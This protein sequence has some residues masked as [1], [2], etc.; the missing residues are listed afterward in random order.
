MKSDASSSSVAEGRLFGIGVGPGDP[1]LLTL[2]AVRV[3]NECAVLAWPAPESGRGLAFDIAAPHLRNESQTR[4]PL[5]LPIG[6]DPF[7]AQQAYD[8]MAERLTPWLESGATVGVLCEGD[9]LFYGS[10]MYLLERLGSQFP[11]TVVPGVSSLMACAAAAKWPL[12]SRNEPFQ[13]L[14][15]PLP[16]EVLEECL[17]RPGTYA[18]MKV[19]RHFARLRGVLREL[20]LLKTSCYIAH[21]SRPDEQVLPLEEVVP[22]EVPYFSMIL[23]KTHA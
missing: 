3:M 18:L 5:H 10:F 8:G 4:L 7:P 11:V 20:G 22:E 2:Q 21:A 15:G 23:V 19:G 9:P 12:V 14:P 1:E 16:N 6:L 13:V 17:S